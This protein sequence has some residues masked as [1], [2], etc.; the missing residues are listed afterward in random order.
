MKSLLTFAALAV[1]AFAFGQNP[2]Q[3][4]TIAAT[5]K[6]AAGASIPGVT[7]QVYGPAGVTTG[8]TDQKG[9]VALRVA[10]GINQVRAS[11]PGFLT[12]STEVTVKDSEAFMLTLTMSVAPRSRLTPSPFQ[13]DRDIDIRASN[14]TLQGNLVLYRGNVQMRT[15]GVEVRAD[16]IDFNTVTRTASA[17]GNVTIQVLPIGPRV[18]PLGN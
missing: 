8:I 1:S 13:R 11:L 5:V 9:S 2:P 4:A 10:P 15:D 6:D 18:T 16:E 12:E 7:V 3:S 14:T 17:R